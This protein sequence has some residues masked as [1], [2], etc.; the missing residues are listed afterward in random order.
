MLGGDVF[1]M[2]RSFADESDN[3]F[4][5]DAQV[6]E[7]L[8]QGHR[9]Y[10]NIVNAIDPGIYLTSKTFTITSNTQDLTT[11]VPP[12]AGAAAIGPTKMDRLIRVARIDT[13]ASDT[14]IE[15]LTPAPNE[16]DVPVFGYCLKGNSIVFGGASSGSYRLE[17]DPVFDYSNVFVGA[18]SAKYID[19]LDA[20]HVI[21]VLLALQYYAI[22]DGAASAEV[23]A[24]LGLRRRE[25]ERYLTEGRH[26]TAS[27]HVLSADYNY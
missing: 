24:Q 12:L 5:T 3:T 11:L 9:E 6:Q 7:Y 15:Y 13:E 8:I 17:Y 22:R 19:D 10:R 23:N 2:F 27:Q 18:T 25:L 26:Q 21:I 16:Q 20:F 1:L 14:V 4:L